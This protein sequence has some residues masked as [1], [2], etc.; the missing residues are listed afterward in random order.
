MDSWASTHSRK[1]TEK[2]IHATGSSSAALE[3]IHAVSVVNFPL[4]LIEQDVVSSL[5]LLELYLDNK[6]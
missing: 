2:V 4:I 6:Y 1:H 3:A 5:D